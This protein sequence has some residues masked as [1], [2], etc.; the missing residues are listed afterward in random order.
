MGLRQQRIWC[1]AKDYHIDGYLEPHDINRNL[2]YINTD[3]LR[4]RH[5]IQDQLDTSQYP[6]SRVQ[7]NYMNFLYDEL[8]RE[9]KLQEMAYFSQN[10]LG[11][12]FVYCIDKLILGCSA[13]F[14]LIKAE[15]NKTYSSQSVTDS[16]LDSI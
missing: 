9:R 5:Q 6:L 4:R 7:D 11:R 1:V 2:V 16:S 15:R 3:D 10:Y 13:S 8:C 14:E 12:I